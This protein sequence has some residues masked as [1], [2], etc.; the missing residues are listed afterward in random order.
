[1]KSVF[2]ILILT[3][4]FAVF[5]LSCSTAPPVL[6]TSDLGRLADLID[7][8][9]AA[10]LAEDSA[11]VFLLDSEVYHRKAEVSYLWQQLAADRMKT[12][13]TT[14]AGSAFSTPYPVTT[15]TYRQFGDNFQTKAFLQR[16]VPKNAYLVQVKTT[17]GIFKLV[18]TPRKG[19]AP[20]IVAMTGPLK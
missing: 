13:P 9:D 1:M 16:Y 20:T 7:A 8:G 14:D 3:C 10:Q 5:V 6:Q 17:L 4:C 12:A 11:P 2:R 15:E 19:V 18:L